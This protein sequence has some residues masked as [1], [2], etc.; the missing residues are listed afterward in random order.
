[1][2]WAGTTGDPHADRV[3]AG[4]LRITVADVLDALAD[5]PRRTHASG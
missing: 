4:L 2:L 5:L 1:V 3:D